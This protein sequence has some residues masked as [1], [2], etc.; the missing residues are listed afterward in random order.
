MQKGNSINNNLNFEENKNLEN[1][2]NE[3]ENSPLDY[4]YE[5]FYNDV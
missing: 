4:Y 3:I 2:D 1:N 5:N